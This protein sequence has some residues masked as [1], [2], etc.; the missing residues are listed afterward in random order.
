MTKLYQAT[1]TVSIKV[2]AN[3]AEDARFAK[4]AETYQRTSQHASD[5][6]KFGDRRTSSVA[7]HCDRSDLTNQRGGGN[8]APTRK[9]TS[10]GQ[11]LDEETSRATR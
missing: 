5:R 1:G 8:V 7:R 4:R 10:N 2:E 6:R 9:G 11:L 3:N